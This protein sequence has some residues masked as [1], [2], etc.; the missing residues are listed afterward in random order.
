L[1]SAAQTSH[2]PALFRKLL[3]FLFSFLWHGPDGRRFRSLAASGGVKQLRRWAS[4]PKPPDAQ[5]KLPAVAFA[6]QMLPGHLVCGFVRIS[7]RNEPRMFL[8]TAATAA[9]IDF[10]YVQ[11]SHDVYRSPKS[12]KGRQQAKR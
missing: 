9:R 4:V 7:G 11:V 8:F 10:V 3:L 1:I 2:G 12:S 5:P 6:V